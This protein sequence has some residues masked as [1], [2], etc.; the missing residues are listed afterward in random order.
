M[1]HDL[2]FLMPSGEER[3]GEQNPFRRAFAGSWMLSPFPASLAGHE[4]V[5][6]SAARTTSGPHLI[7]QQGGCKKSHLW[8][9]C[10][11]NALG[12]H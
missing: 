1:S 4:M 8:C 9:W 11:M 5:L 3:K 12:A 10:S 6:G 2:A 7:C